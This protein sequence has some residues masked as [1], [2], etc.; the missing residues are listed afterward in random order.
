MSAKLLHELSG[1]L[2]N[3]EESCCCCGC[4]EGYIARER[5]EYAL[6][7]NSEVSRRVFMGI[8][9]ERVERFAQLGYFD[10]EW[11]DRVFIT[12]VG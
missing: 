3:I 5:V 9:V 2:G 8:L 12:N 1:V 4:C 7:G 6:F 11:C 10:F